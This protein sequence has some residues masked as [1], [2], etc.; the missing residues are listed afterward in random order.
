MANQTAL[1][2]TDEPT[3][4]Q[5][6]KVYQTLT[7]LRYEAPAEIYRRANVSPKLR[8]LDDENKSVPIKSGTNITGYDTQLTA[9]IRYILKMITV[10]TGLNLDRERATATVKLLKEMLPKYYGM[11]TVSEMV[12][13]FELNVMAK[14]PVQDGTGQIPHFNNFSIDYVGKVLKAYRKYRNEHVEIIIQ[15]ID[16]GRTVAELPPPALDPVARER[17]MISFIEL[18]FEDYKKTKQVFLSD[19]V[20]SHMIEMEIIQADAFETFRDRARSKLIG[21]KSM[22]HI[23]AQ[24][25]GTKEHISNQIHALKIGGSNDGVD[26]MARK[27]CVFEYFDKLLTPF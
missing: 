20:Y 17:E 1:I 24:R 18:C 22:D 9:A 13:A 7:A 6:L 12:Y 11:L 27:L 14:L 8:D 2:K 16:C 21:Q 5:S 10:L 4:P 26:V 25:I 15:A 23:G 19:I 3:D